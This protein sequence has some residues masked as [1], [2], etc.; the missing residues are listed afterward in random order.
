MR[1]SVR[2]RIDFCMGSLA[3]DLPRLVACESRTAMRSCY[4][5]DAPSSIINTNANV[6]KIKG[7]N[8]CV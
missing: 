2:M 7:K 6:F 5:T 1:A 3:H 4:S 8:N